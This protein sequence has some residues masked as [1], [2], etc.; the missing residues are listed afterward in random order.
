VEWVLRQGSV[1]NTDMALRSFAA[2]VNGPFEGL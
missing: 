1:R 2:F